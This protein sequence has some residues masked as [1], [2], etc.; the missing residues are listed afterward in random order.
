MNFSAATNLRTANISDR[1]KLFAGHYVFLLQMTLTYYVIW[2]KITL[3]CVI[4]RK[5]TLCK[6]LNFFTSDFGI[7]LIFGFLLE[8]NSNNVQKNE[9]NKSQ[10]K[11]LTLVQWKF[12]HKVIWCN[13]KSFL[14]ILRYI[15]SEHVMKAVLYFAEPDH[16]FNL[17]ADRN[18]KHVY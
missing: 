2:Q 11:N 7:L 5:I 17:I 15:T 16:N 6:N 10:W 1:K 18:K 9:E 8:N 14:V 4:L 13:I 12:V 3:Y